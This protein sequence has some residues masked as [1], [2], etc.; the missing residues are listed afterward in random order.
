ME[1]YGDALHLALLVILIASLSFLIGLCCGCKK[2]AC[3]QRWRA[4]QGSLVA[5]CEEDDSVFDKACMYL[6][7]HI[8]ICC[9]TGDDKLTCCVSE[10]WVNPVADSH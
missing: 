3:V 9:T 1:L 6:F 10:K 4:W 7:L 2:A 5:S 8:L